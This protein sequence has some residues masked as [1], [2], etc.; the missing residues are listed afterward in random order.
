MTKGGFILRIAI[1]D[2]D[3]GVYEDLKAYI[4]GFLGNSAEFSYFPNGEA[5]LE[6]REDFDLIILDIFMGRLTGMDVAREIRKTD[7]DVKIV[8][9]TTSNEFASESYEVNACYY[10]HKPFG[11]ERVKAMLDRLGIAKIEKMRTLKLPDGTNVRLRDIIYI[12]C[13]SHCVTLHGKR[14]NTVVRMN[15]S[16]A[17]P[18]FCEYPYFYSP[19]K[20]II[21]NFYEVAARDGTVFKM[22]DGSL[23]PISRRKAKEVLDAYSS[24]LFEKLRKGEEM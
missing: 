13:A 23:I 16:E 8:F 6:K 1:V 4:D 22:S 24:F 5:F 14:E 21:V 11:K 3:I 18:L 19:T 10:L 7:G 9:A 2:D 12:D 20:G 17:E 15:F